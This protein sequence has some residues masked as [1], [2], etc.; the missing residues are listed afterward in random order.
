MANT[1]LTPTAVLRMAL[2]ILH[3]KLNFV[4]TI[5]R[6]YDDKFAKE[7]GKIGS[8]L[9]LRLPNQYTV[10]TGAVMTTQDTTENSVVLTVATQKHVGIN[11]SSNELTLSIDDFAER[12]LAPAMAVLASAVE[13]DAL[14]MINDIYQASPVSTLANALD[15]KTLLGGKKRMDDG[16]APPDNRRALLSTQNMVDLVTDVKGLFQDS[17][18]LKKQ[19]K[20]GMMGTTA[21][22]DFYQN[23]LLTKFTSG[24]ETAAG[25]VVI[26]G[27]SQTGATI[28]VTNG[29][30]KTYT[31]GDIVTLPGVN[32]VHPETKADTGQLQ[33]FVLTAAMASG[34]TSI[35]ISPAIVI[36]GAT[37]NVTASPTTTGTVLKVTGDASKVTDGSLLYH[38]EAFALATADLLMPKGVDFSAREVQD[39][40]S[41][42]IVR[43][44]DINNDKFPCRIDILY[45]FKT[46]RAA[47]AAR[48]ISNA[49]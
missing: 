20:E 10:T 14:S 1:L 16:L 33:Q 32:R 5:E 29:S 13:A 37:Q 15:L 47:L 27:A 25:T 38:K 12:I 48:L 45:G 39:G 34:G 11:F 43:Q 8:T 23:T 17:A 6:Q 36:T 18:A 41:L 40:L 9:T 46:I 35:A 7:G 42:R 4:G 44:Y 31:K 49:V 28:N 22:F 26:N 30:S 2:R 3:Q 21:G 19:Y 24:T